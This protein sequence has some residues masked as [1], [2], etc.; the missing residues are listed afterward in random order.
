M[1]LE[2]LELISADDLYY[3]P[4][5]HPEMLIDGLLS[6]GLAI[7]SGD[8]KIG[9][10]WLVLWLGLKIAKGEPVWGIPTR[11]SDVVYLALEDCDW[12]LQ[13]RM[14]L[15]TDEPPENLHIGFS[16]GMIGQELEDQILELLKKYPTVGIIFLDTFQKVRENLSSKVNA[17]AKDY[18]DLSSL[19]KIA[20][21]NNICIFLVHHTRKERD[22]SNVFHDITGST[23]I[24]G[25]ADTLMVLQKENHFSDEALLCVTGRD[26]EERVLHLKMSGN[27]WEAVEEI[28]PKRRQTKEVPP[29]IFRI[30]EYFLSNDSFIGTMTD[31]L[32]ELHITDMQP[33]VASRHLSKHF[34]PVLKPLGLHYESH[35]STAGRIIGIWRDHD[36][37]D[38]N[39]DYGKND[40][41]P[42]SS[43]EQDDYRARY[44]TMMA[45]ID[46]QLSFPRESSIS[47]IPSMSSKETPAEDW[48]TIGESL[49]N[50]PFQG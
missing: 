34:D 18:R 4:I 39:D 28:S 30:A 29:V 20:D 16:C 12:R 37:N 19:K 49:E 11:K 6:T 5:T 21:Q 8:S 17:Y 35:R 41:T 50:C 13:D 42:S 15:L 9:K 7:L 24:A 2:E 27:I 46:G 45:G 47:S 43:K 48:K 40:R 10:S 22:G 26:V 1:T 33:N 38:G 36:D 32:K 3:K 44:M 25:V 14:Q 23:G 31:F